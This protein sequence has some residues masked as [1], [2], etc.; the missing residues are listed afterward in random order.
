MGRSLSQYVTDVCRRHQRAGRHAADGRA[1]DR[2]G[3]PARL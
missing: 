3:Q 2:A 1:S